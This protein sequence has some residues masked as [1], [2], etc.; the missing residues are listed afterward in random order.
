MKPEQLNNILDELYESGRHQLIVDSIEELPK[1]EWNYDVKIHL[2]RAYNNISEYDKALNILLSKSLG[3]SKDV[4][5]NYVVGYAYFHKKKYNLALK[6]FEISYDLGRTDVKYYIDLCKQSIK[7]SSY[8]LKIL[9][10]KY[11]EFGF[12]ISCITNTPNNHNTNARSYFKTPSH[13]W[14]DLF[15]TDQ[16]EFDL[17]KFDWVNS[18]GLGTFTYWK[19]LAVIDIDGCNDEQFIKQ[20][21]RK[22]NLPNDYEWVVQSGSKNGFHIYYRGDQIDECGQDDVV[23]AFPPKKQFEKYVDKIEFLWK[24]HTV[25]PPSVHGSG[26]K[27]SFLNN[28]FPQ[29]KPVEIDTET[30]YD[31]INEF[32]DFDKIQVGTGYGGVMNKISSKVDFVDDFS[33]DED[34]TKH[35]LDDLY[36]IVDIETSGLP[37]NTAN[38][39]IYPEI[40][41][42]A[43]VVTNKKGLVLKKNS[44]IIETVFIK[45]NNYSSIVNIDFEVARKV[46]FPLQHALKKLTEDIKICD[47]VVTH[48]TEFDLSIL[49]HYY[50]K[51][52]GTNPLLRKATICTMKS[53]VNYCKIPNNYGFKYPK[54]SELYEKLFDY[55][56]KNSHNAEVDVLHTLKCFKKLKDL[57]VL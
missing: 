12:N 39:T 4:Y 43:W 18:V 6:H 31:F 22:L 50:V 48:N 55:Q 32:L 38:G 57:N 47:Y 42:I 54:L 14:T 3:G 30:I 28:G 2:A 26:N 10:D 46:M 41:Q 9:A 1:I 15:K 36:L 8:K 13:E 21:L 33:D 17:N 51:I 44:F 53:T 27:Y 20:I 40:I 49:G 19:D 16:S 11:K 56:V 5:W 7:N 34:I 24:T 25:L 35:L 23:S 52:Y 45:K 37:Q 29:N